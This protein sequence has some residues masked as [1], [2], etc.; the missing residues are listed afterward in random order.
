MANLEYKDNRVVTTTGDID[1]YTKI[2][3]GELSNSNRL[4]ISSRNE[5]SSLK[6]NW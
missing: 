2:I 3:D 5:N 4:I 6:V 1:N